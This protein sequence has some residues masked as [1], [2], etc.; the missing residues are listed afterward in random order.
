[1]PSYTPCDG[2]GKNAIN[3]EQYP[4]TPPGLGGSPSPARTFGNC[5]DCGR[6]VGVRGLAQFIKINRHKAQQED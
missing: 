6:T 1:M 5:P 3:I 4:G 2:T